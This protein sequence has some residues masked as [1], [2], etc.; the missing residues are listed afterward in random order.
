[1]RETAP[2]FTD[3]VNTW[4]IAAFDAPRL[5]FRADCR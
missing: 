1:L 3:Q 5:P 2:P 4:L